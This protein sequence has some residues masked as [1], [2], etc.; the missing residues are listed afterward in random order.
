MERNKH[1]FTQFY[2]IL[3]FMENFEYVDFNQVK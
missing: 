3:K 2:K 1:G